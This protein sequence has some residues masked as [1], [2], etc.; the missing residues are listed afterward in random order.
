VQELV[1]G[2]HTDSRKNHWYAIRG[3]VIGTGL[4]VRGINFLEVKNNVIEHTLGAGIDFTGSTQVTVVGNTIRFTGQ[5][6]NYSDTMSKADGISG[7]HAT[8]GNV[9]QLIVIDNNRISESGN[10]GVHV[11]GR[12]IQVT[13]NTVEMSRGHGIYVGDWRD[14]DGGDDNCSYDIVVKNNTVTGVGSG[15]SFYHLFVQDWY[16]KDHIVF[17]ENRPANVQWGRNANCTA[18]K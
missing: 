4:R 18:K 15:G 14:T 3:Q 1:Q 5:N 10:H 17:T 8:L 12:G 2:H 16:L 6:A 7:Y 9:D 13:N 11:S